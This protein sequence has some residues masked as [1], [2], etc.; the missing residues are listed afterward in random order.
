MTMKLISAII[1]PGRLAKIRA[2]A[3]AL[4]GFPGMTIDKVEGFSTQEEAPRSIQAELTDDSVKYRLLIIS[5]DEQVDAI[6]EMIR[7]ACRT[8]ERGDGHI[9]VNP[10]ETHLRIRDANP[11][12]GI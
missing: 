1:Q 10:I 12:D 5:P 8:G 3:R 4:P 2:A 9:W 11:G 7:T 6:I